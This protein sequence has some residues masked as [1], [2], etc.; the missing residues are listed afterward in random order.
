MGTRNLAGQSRGGAVD[1]PN[2]VTKP[3][4]E[5]AVRRKATAVDLGTE[6]RR[7]KGT[8]DSTD[9]EPKSRGKSTTN[10][11]G[12]RQSHVFL[13]EGQENSVV[14]LNKTQVTASATM[15]RPALSAMIPT[16]LQAK[17]K[18]KENPYENILN[19][20]AYFK[21]HYME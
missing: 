14:A 18:D 13:I 17:E 11:K 21:K 2:K 1:S 3:N 19:Y 5:S 10:E 12:K 16:T 6:P 8:I 7:R 4:V 15:I 20:K 9:E